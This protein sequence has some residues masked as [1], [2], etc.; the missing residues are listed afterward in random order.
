MD[1]SDSRAVPRNLVSLQGEGREETVLGV[2]HTYR[3][4][5]QQ[6]GGAIA[7]V[8]LVV[9][10]GHGIPP[11][12]HQLEDEIFYVTEGSVE[13][14]GDDLA[15]PA[16]VPQGALFYGP[17]GKMHG[18]RNGGAVPARL[19]LFMTPGGNMQRMFAALAELTMNSHSMPAIEEV[20]R[21]CAKFDM[22]IGPASA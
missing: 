2:T 22:V 16:T 19:L 8:D 13:I 10:P 1:Q 9:G 21:L 5:E 17:R 12:S 3:L 20:D 4:E 11:H 14:V 7:C 6:T 18:F 15:G